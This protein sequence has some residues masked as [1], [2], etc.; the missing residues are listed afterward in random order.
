MTND[1]NQD[2]THI[3]D[4]WPPTTEIIENGDTKGVSIVTTHMTPG[5]A[6]EFREL[7]GGIGG[8]ALLVALISWISMAAD[9]P[10]RYTGTVAIIGF[11]LGVFM[12]RA[13]VTHF[14]AK[15]VFPKKT[16]IRF[17]GRTLFIKKKAYSLDIPHNFF[18]AEHD[19]A[20]REAMQTEIDMG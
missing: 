8:F 5:R 17:V 11:I 6:K 13:S 3:F 16:K 2:I 4:G 12:L 19:K 15:K 14:F 1:N 9:D 10:P 20:Q 7:S 18:L